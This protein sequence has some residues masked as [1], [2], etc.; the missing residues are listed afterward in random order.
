MQRCI[1]RLVLAQLAVLAAA[2]VVA[3]KVGAVPIVTLLAGDA[4]A[5]PGY[6]GL[7]RLRYGGTTGRTLAEGLTLRQAALGPTYAV[8]D[9]RVDLLVDRVVSGPASSH[10]ALL[11]EGSVCRE[12]IVVA[13]GGFSSQTCLRSHP[14][15]RFDVCHFVRRH[16]TVTQCIDVSATQTNCGPPP[17]SIEPAWR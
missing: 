5:H 14:E 15:G 8:L 7:A 17:M 12:M 3:G 1:T 6:C 16:S 13:N 4:K 9:G 11:K 2:A 10:V